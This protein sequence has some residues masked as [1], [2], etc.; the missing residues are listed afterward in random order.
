MAPHLT[1]LSQLSTHPLQQQVLPPTPNSKSCPHPQPPELLQPHYPQS[2]LLLQKL[3]TRLPTSTLSPLKKP[4][5]KKKKKKK[6]I[7]LLNHQSEH[8][9]LLLKTPWGLPCTTDRTGT[10]HSGPIQEAET[11]ASLQPLT[12]ARPSLASALCPSVLSAWNALP[13]SRWGLRLLKLRS[14][15]QMPSSQKG[16][17]QPSSSYPFVPL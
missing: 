15:F 12:G 3:L 7:C 16:L 10:P 1:V 9:T 11:R 13:G 6:A 4:N 8:V 17:S 5:V 2:H 14:Q